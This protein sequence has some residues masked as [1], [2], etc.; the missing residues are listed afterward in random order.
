MQQALTCSYSLC[1]VDIEVETN[2]HELPYVHT[3][4]ELRVAYIR[5]IKEHLRDARTNWFLHGGSKH[6]SSDG[7]VRLEP[8]KATLGLLH[9]RR[10]F[11]D[12][13][14]RPLE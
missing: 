14:C 2:N 5:Q 8:D 13:L 11:P 7:D 3:L 6:D 10:T 9:Q 12:R 4:R 1:I